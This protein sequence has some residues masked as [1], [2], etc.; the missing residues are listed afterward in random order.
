MRRIN[1]H[2]DQVDHRV[3]G[4]GAGDGNRGYDID[5][6]DRGDSRY[7]VARHHRYRVVVGGDIVKG[8]GDAQFAGGRVLVRDDDVGDDGVGLRRLSRVGG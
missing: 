5:R 1:H 6:D 4:G 8:G 3:G 7:A 2:T